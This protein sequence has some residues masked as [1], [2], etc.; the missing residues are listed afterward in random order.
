MS[1]TVSM[2]VTA[3]YCFLF[4]A[5]IFLAITLLEVANIVPKLIQR[6][7]VRNAC[8]TEL[9]TSLPAA[10]HCGT[11]RQRHSKKRLRSSVQLKRAEARGIRFRSSMECRRL[12]ARVSYEQKLETIGFRICPNPV[13]GCQAGLHPILR[14]ETMAATRSARL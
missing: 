5:S 3:P 4:S 9:S 13:R 14:T 11:I 12:T 10:L 8:S 7:S 1:V 2:A 6:C